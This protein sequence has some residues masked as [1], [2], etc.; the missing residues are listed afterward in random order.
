MTIVSLIE[1][2]FACRYTS[3]ENVYDVLNDDAL[4]LELINTLGAVYN[5][6]R[7]FQIK[8]DGIIILTCEFTCEW[9]PVEENMAILTMTRYGDDDEVCA[10]KLRELI[11]KLKTKHL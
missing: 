10:L 5:E 7:S 4:K 1:V 8:V 11:Q 9:D 3:N 6:I 2:V